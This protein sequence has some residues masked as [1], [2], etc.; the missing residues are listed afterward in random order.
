MG[1]EFDFRMRSL[2][3]FYLGRGRKTSQNLKLKHILFRIIEKLKTILKLTRIHAIN[4]GKFVF[5][6]K[7]L[8]GI[9]GKIEGNQFFLKY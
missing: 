6:Y 4:L 2:W 3:C 9:L 1:S 8:R 5:S 7:L